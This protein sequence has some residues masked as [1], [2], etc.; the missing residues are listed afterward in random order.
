MPHVRRLAVGERLPVGDDQL[1]VAHA[2]RGEVGIE[3]LAHPSPLEGEPDVASPGARRT[4]PGLVAF[5]PDCLVPRP[6]LDPRGRLDLLGRLDLGTTGL[7]SSIVPVTAVARVT[8]PASVRT[9]LWV[10]CAVIR[11]PYPAASVTNGVP[12]A[13]AIT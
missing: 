13:P 8:T 11:G 4:E 6:G 12:R 5:G 3:H 10:R 9:A 2:R 7:V 1:E